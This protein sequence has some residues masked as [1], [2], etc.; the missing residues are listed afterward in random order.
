MSSSTTQDDNNELPPFCRKRYPF[1]RFRLCDT[2]R[3]SACSR[4]YAPACCAQHIRNAARKVID[5][6]NLAA[7]TFLPSIS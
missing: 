2:S 5:H 3:S 6:V 1:R 7:K 4:L